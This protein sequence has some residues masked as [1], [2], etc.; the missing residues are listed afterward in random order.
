MIV[1]F[2]PAEGLRLVEPQDFKSFKLRLRDT[3]EA[4]PT[5]PSVAFVDDVNVLISVDAVPR[6]PGAP[7]TPEWKA[8]FDRMVDYAAGKG[9]I[10][11]V[12]KAIRAHVE[13]AA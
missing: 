11:P 12:T 3:D 8:G 10:D 1:D 13:R 7:S 5:I 6:L 9:W 2:S 4:R